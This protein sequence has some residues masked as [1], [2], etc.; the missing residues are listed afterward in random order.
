MTFETGNSEAAL[1]TPEEM[2]RADKLTIESGVPGIV[3]MERAGQAVARAVGERV[4]TGD[5]VLF[6]CG[7]GN[8]GGDGFIAARCLA[9]AGY[10]VRIFVLKDPAELKGDALEAFD[11][12][13]P[14]AS[15]HCG[16]AI[17]GDDIADDFISSLGSSDLVIDAL[18]GAGLD[19]PLAGTVL[20]LVE[21]VNQSGV[22]VLAVDLPSGVSGASGLI[23]GGAIKSCATVTFFRAKPG[24]FL[25]PGRELCGETR[26]ADI[27][28][29]VQ[30]LEEISPDTFHNSPELWL[31]SWPRPGTSAHKYSRGHAVVFG[32]P[33]SSTG[34]AR[35]SAGAAL[36]A[37]AGLVTLA[38]PPDA[39]MVNA[40]HLTAVMLRKVSDA[41]S[42]AGFLADERLNA[43]LIGPGFGVGA[44]TRTVVE[45][46]LAAN[47]AIVLDADA[48]TSFSEDPDALFGMI[49]SSP[50]P[51]L[52]TPH[53]GEFS[54]LFPDIA[55]DKLQRARLAAERSGA[56]LVLKG[57]DSVIAAPDGRAAINRNAPPWL[58]TAGSGDVLAGIAVG[59]LAQGVPGFEAGCQTVWLHGEAG[60]E[61]GP[62]LTAEDLAPALKSVI[63]GVVDKSSVGRG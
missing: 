2:G 25:L 38:S 53:E 43:L 60:L 12:L 51:V 29:L 52:L 20:Q 63:R 42:I 4:A 50:A 21:L 5:K 41:G 61:S 31:G 28:I 62:G 23:L 54:R 48:L 8:N 17:E 33:M 7:P 26:V 30:T 35:L 57:P 47:R 6:L 15:N 32:G 10:A 40:C 59:L 44:T 14:V 27:G 22:P 16:K 45:A 49:R 37:G 55:G 1:L 56:I 36:R 3:L 13:G 11:R 58:A 46:L 19:R 24:H 18:F 39:M 9:A 34:A